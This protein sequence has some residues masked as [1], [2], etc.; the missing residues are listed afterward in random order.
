MTSGILRFESPNDNFFS[1]L[2]NEPLSVF[3]AD[4]I[5]LYIVSAWENGAYFMQCLQFSDRIR[6]GEVHDYG[7]I[8]ES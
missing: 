5:L 7:M 2:G 6:E 8:S 3:G 4:K 1:F